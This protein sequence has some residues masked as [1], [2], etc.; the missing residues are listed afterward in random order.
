MVVRHLPA[1]LDSILL[2]RPQIKLFLFK[3]FCEQSA[4]EREFIVFTGQQ[5]K[6]NLIAKCQQETV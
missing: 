2:S 3:G 5:Y 6:W 4:S 1:S